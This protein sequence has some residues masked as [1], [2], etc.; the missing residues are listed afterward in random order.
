M[1]RPARKALIGA[2][3]AARSRGLRRHAFPRSAVALFL[4]LLVALSLAVLY[5][6]AVSRSLGT[7]WSWGWDSLALPS[8]ATSQEE[9]GAEGDDLVSLLASTFD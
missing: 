9:D 8:F 2:P 5:R 4:A 6:A 1:A 7:S 3:S